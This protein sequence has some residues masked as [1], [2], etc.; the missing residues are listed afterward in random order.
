MVYRKFYISIIVRVLLIAINCLV[1]FYY[2]WQPG[3]LHLK[4]AL[5]AIFVFQIFYL[6]WFLNRI[7]RRLSLFFDAIKSDDFN[8]IYSD[9]SKR[10]EFKELNNQLDKLT[11]YFR[12]LK[13][14]NEQH[15]LYFKA[16]IEHVGAGIFAFNKIGRIRFINTAALEILGVSYLKNIEGLENLKQG[17]SKNIQQLK[18][19]QQQL[20]EIPTGNE[21]LQLTARLTIYQFG[22]EQLNLVSLQN[23]RSE[24]EQQETQT[25]QKMIRVLTHEIV[26]SISPI[27]SLAAS[28]SRIVN[29]EVDSKEEAS[30]SERKLVKGLGTIKSRGEG[31]VDFVEKYRKL[32]ILPDPQI[33]EIKVLDLFSDVKTLF[34]EQIQKEQIQFQVSCEPNDLILH[35]DR[36]QMEQVLI[37]LIKNA[38]WVVRS[39][40]HKEIALFANSATNG[41]TMITIADNGCGIESDLMDKIFIPFFTSHEGGSGIGLSLSRQIMLMHRGSISVQSKLKEGTSFYLKFMD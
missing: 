26:N 13:I 38:L 21:I 29:T 2:W 15:D 14:E 4:F 23:I 28:L 37:N 36:E 19:G 9:Y 35:A 27:T 32:T 7:N 3:M 30:P 40:D 1:L 5:A 33:A 12:E 6:I 25:W 24:L 41:Q 16:V 34:D 39:V 31:L 18:P 10:G 20:L 17:L 22:E 8:V 11:K